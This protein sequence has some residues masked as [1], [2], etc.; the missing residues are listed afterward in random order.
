MFLLPT[1]KKIEVN[2]SGGQETHPT[3]GYRRW[4]GMAVAAEPIVALAIIE[5]D[6]CY[7]W[8]RS[9]TRQDSLEMGILF[10][11]SDTGGKDISVSFAVGDSVVCQNCSVPSRQTE[12]DP[13]PGVYQTGNIIRFAELQSIRPV[14][15]HVLFL[16]KV[17]V[18][19]GRSGIWHLKVPHERS[20]DDTWKR[21][22]TYG[23]TGIAEKRR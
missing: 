6:E 1:V 2:V 12:P 23:R 13:L 21:V 7:S 20:L 3:A 4:S 11:P 5:N 19:T 10:S 22:L 16:A 17:D 14:V 15:L 18:K 8:V 9:S